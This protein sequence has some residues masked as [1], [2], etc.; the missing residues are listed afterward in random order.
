MAWR[1]GISGLVL[2][3]ILVPSLASGQGLGGTDEVVILS[4]YRSYNGANNL[5]RRQPLDHC[6]KICVLEQVRREISERIESS[7]IT[8]R[9]NG[10]PLQPAVSKVWVQQ[11]R[12]SVFFFLGRL[13]H[14]RWNRGIFRND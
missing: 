11:S 2:A 10:K 1:A 9:A 7:L 12:L 14:H 8:L 13:V 5:P 3:A 4:T 6:G